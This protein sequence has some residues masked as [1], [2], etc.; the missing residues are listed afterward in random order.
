MG[1]GHIHH[2][3]EGRVALYY[4]GKTEGQLWTPLWFGKQ[5]TRAGFE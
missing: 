5:N 4:T 2:M 1:S 3:P